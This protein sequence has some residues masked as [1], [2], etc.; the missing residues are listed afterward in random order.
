MDKASQQRSTDGV[1]FMQRRRCFAVFLL[2]VRILVPSYLRRSPIPVQ[3]IG[4][5][6]RNSS[7]WIHLQLWQLW[8]E[9]KDACRTLSQHGFLKNH[10]QLI[11]AHRWHSM[12]MACGASWACFLRGL[13]KSLRHGALA[14]LAWERWAAENWQMVD[15]KDIPP[16]RRYRFWLGSAQSFGCWQ[17]TI[18]SGCI[19]ID[20]QMSIFGAAA[21]QVLAL[22]RWCYYVCSSTYLNTDQNTT[23][24]YAMHLKNYWLILPKSRRVSGFVWICLKSEATLKPRIDWQKTLQLNNPLKQSAENLK[25]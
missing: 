14:V 1:L 19:E 2:L 16:D 13:H 17:M 25:I 15:S 18:Y 3:T 10:L 22:S 21:R 8:P 23:E 7:S 24:F 4:E 9:Y 11:R 20:S 5:V 6:G 12:T